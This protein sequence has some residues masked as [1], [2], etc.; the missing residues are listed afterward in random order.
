[1]Q[2]DQALAALR[3][4]PG[5]ESDSDALARAA[6]GGDLDA[7]EGLVKRYQRRVYAL[8][9][10]HLRDADE[11]QDLAQEVFVRLYRNLERYD[12]DRPFEPWFWRLAANV[13]ATYRRHRPASAVELTDVAAAPAGAR[14]EAL[15]LARALADLNDQLRLPVLLHYYLDLPLEEIAAA[16]GLSISAVKSRLHRARA[17]LRRLLVE[18][19]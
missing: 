18:E 10:Q 3:A 6:R 19:D 1:M 14:D 9:Y 17:L 4:H 12:P 16:M 13:A 2:A 15:P 11:A 8:A 5:E 7:F